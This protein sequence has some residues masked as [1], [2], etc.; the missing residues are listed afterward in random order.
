LTPVAAAAITPPDLKA[1][2]TGMDIE[3]TTARPWLAEYPVGVPAEI[4]FT[5]YTSL[6]DLLGKSAGK[7][8]TR[9][10][11]HQLGVDIT[12]RQLDEYSARLAAYFQQTLKLQPGDRIAL[13]LPN[14]IQYPIAMFAAARAG[15]IIVNV[16][17]LYTAP[18]LVT[19]IADSMPRA[20]V[21]LETFA[22]TLER[23]LKT[24]AVE[25]VIVARI[26]EFQPFPRSVAMDYVIRRKKKLV[27]AWNIPGAVKFGRALRAHSAAA[28]VA[29]A[30]SR[31]TTAFLQYTGGTTGAPKGAVLTHGNVLADVLMFGEWWK[32]AFRPEG[33]TALIALPL[34]H[35]A[36]LVCQC[37]VG[38]HFGTKS[39]LVINPRDIPALV[40]DFATHKPSIFA[41]LNTLFTALMNN[42]DFQR[43]DFSTL[44]FTGAG[45]TATQPAI[46]DRWQALTGCTV[47]E[48]YGLSE[49]AGAATANPVTRTKF[50]GTIGVPLPSVIV[51]IRDAA[52]MALPPG[53]AGEICI[54]G[55]IVMRG[56]YNRPDETAKVIGPDGYFA[57]GDIGVMSATGAIKIVDRKKDMVLVSGFNVYPNEVEEVLFRHPGILEV[58]VIGIADAQSGEIPVA[59]VV[60]KD[61]SLE[62]SD[63][64]AYARENLAAYKVPRRVV[65]IDE[66]PKTPVGKVLRRQ[67]RDE[68]AG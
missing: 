65:F 50:D 63:V 11:Y 16:N 3:T 43:L 27:P 58:A 55:P 44:R 62:D 21:V 38:I 25:T 54:K 34:Y 35:V 40:Q 4:D 66:L 37:L 47:I 52:G 5:A 67:L 23:A 41:G 36:A 10:A 51:E 61:P 31:E 18:E 8:G 28:F 19:L 30:L 33:D 39:V 14:V 68:L 57:T 56:Y 26:A 48:A 49:T 2:E 29:P 46:A 13:M 6:A 9:I 60:R 7:F 42:A 1:V 20:I 59:C 45:G 64:I 32:S 15:L 22:A 12:F 53:S 17:P 24:V